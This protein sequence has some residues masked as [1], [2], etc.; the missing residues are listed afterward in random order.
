MVHRPCG[1]IFLWQWPWKTPRR[2]LS[3]SLVESVTSWIS[4]PVCHNS[5]QGSWDRLSRTVLVHHDQNLDCSVCCFFVD[6]D[7]KIFIRVHNLYV[8]FKD[9][10]WSWDVPALLWFYWCWALS[11]LLHHSTELPIRC[12]Y[13]SSLP[14]LMVRGVLRAPLFAWHAKS[15]GSN[16]WPEP[17]TSGA[18]GPFSNEGKRNQLKTRFS[19]LAN[20]GSPLWPVSCLHPIF[21]VILP[22]LVLYS[23]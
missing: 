8:L 23:R 22:C 18:A 20:S 10:E 12:L 17:G 6:V 7:S 2:D 9:G 11:S 13:F 1:T 14:L 19:S 4:L 5:L 16:L 3:C 21:D 15:R